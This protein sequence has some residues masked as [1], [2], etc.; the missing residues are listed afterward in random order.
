M[1]T[2]VIVLI[3]MSVYMNPSS[4]Y[5][6]LFCYPFLACSS[7]LTRDIQE[8][9][10]SWV[11]VQSDCWPK[12]S[13]LVLTSSSSGHSGIG[14][15]WS[16][17]EN[18]GP[19]EFSAGQMYSCTTIPSV[20]PSCHLAVPNCCTRATWH[21]NDLNASQYFWVS[22]FHNWV[23]LRREYC[24]WWTALYSWWPGFLSR[25]KP[26]RSSHSDMSLWEVLSVEWWSKSMEAFLDSCFRYVHVMCADH[27]M[28]EE[29]MMIITGSWELLSNTYASTVHSCIQTL[30]FDALG[31]TVWLYIIFMLSRQIAMSQSPKSHRHI[32]GHNSNQMPSQRVRI[33]EL[34]PLVDCQALPPLLQTLLSRHMMSLLYPVLRSGLGALLCPVLRPHLSQFQP[35]LDCQCICR[36]CCSLNAFSPAKACL[37]KDTSRCPKQLSTKSGWL[38]SS[39][40]REV[41]AAIC[42][43]FGDVTCN[44]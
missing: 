16:W 39:G 14:V 23:I 7:P 10:T 9:Q 18:P 35:F 32:Y 27:A 41:E 30:I 25:Q 29:A 43:L 26:A 19:C 2:A 31:V 4:P 3:D 40:S 20:Q 13:L 44:R 11:Q 1:R 15:P 36:E 8:I 12:S 38:T 22:T 21:R 37:D 5:T 33:D 17:G 28:S 6:P 34:C 42:F 24:S